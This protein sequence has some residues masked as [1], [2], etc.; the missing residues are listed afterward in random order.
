MNQ[1]P[2]Q[3]GTDLHLMVSGK[4]NQGFIHLTEPLGTFMIPFPSDFFKDL[5][6]IK[7][8]RRVFCDPLSSKKTSDY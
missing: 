1:T 8:K 6:F 5:G 3:L 2:R 7:I 4:K